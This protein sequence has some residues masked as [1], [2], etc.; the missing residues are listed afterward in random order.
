M[1]MYD[2][3]I[4][5]ASPAFAGGLFA[6]EPSGRPIYHPQLIQNHLSLNVWG[7]NVYNSISDSKIMDKI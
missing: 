3:G 5:P 4:K 2:T 7:N 6:T 1:F